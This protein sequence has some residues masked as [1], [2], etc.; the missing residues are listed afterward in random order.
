MCNVK[1]EIVTILNTLPYQIK[2]CGVQEVV[3]VWLIVKHLVDRVTV[4][5]GSNGHPVY[6]LSL[7]RL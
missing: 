4:D 1:A 6:R 2:V 7:E 3:Y 5:K